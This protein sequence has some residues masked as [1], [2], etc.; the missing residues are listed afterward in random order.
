MKASEILIKSAKTIDYAQNWTRNIVARDFSYKGCEPRD[1]NAVCWC[2]LGAIEKNLPSHLT[3]LL[4]DDEVD[5]AVFYL[6]K[7]MSLG[8]VMDKPT[9]S[10][11]LR[12]LNLVGEVNDRSTHL[13][14]LQYFKTAIELAKK[15]ENAQQD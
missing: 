9:T 6:A 15:E 7:A 2:S 5:K 3:V 10:G 8:R 12:D 1:A 13:Q 14:V 4:G 11:A